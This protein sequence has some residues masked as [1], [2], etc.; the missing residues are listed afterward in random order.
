VLRYAARLLADWACLELLTHTL[1]FNSL[2][3]FGVGGRYTQHGLRYGPFEIGAPSVP[4][5]AGAPPL[6]HI[7]PPRPPAPKW[8]VASAPLSLPRPSFPKAPRHSLQP[9][10]FFTVCDSYVACRSQALRYPPQVT[11]PCSLGAALARLLHTKYFSVSCM[12]P[13]P[14]PFSPQP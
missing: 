11:L 5:R 14:F 3:K 10:L 12:F 9:Y 8:E 1:Y 2:A 6:P 13:L 7:A 4:W